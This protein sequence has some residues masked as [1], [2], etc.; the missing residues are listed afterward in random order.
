MRLILLFA[1]AAVLSACVPVGQVAEIMADGGERVLREPMREPTPGPRVLV[2]GLDG[3]GD[4]ILRE[5]LAAGAMPRLAELVEP[6][7]GDVWAHAYA[8][9]R[10]PSVFPSE[11]AAGWAALF[12]GQPPAVN[13]VTGNEWFDR[14]S[15]AVYAP[16]PLSVG[17]IR[18]TLQI[19][20]DDLLGRL[21]VAPTLFER[22]DV[23]SHVSMGFVHRGADVLNPPDLGDL[24]DL[25]GVA[26]RIVTG[27]D[28]VAAGFRALDNDTWTGVRRSARRYGLPRLQVAYFPGVDLAMHAG[29]RGD[30]DGEFAH[31]TDVVDRRI[32]DILDLYASEG[33]LRD[34]Y[35]LV[36]SDHGH[37]P[38]LDDDRHSLYSGSPGEPPDLFASI[39]VRLRPFEIGA[40]TTDDDQAVMTYNEAVAM[41][42][43]TDRS[44]CPNAG[45]TCD[46]T[47]GPRLVEDVLPVA[48]AF[49]EAHAT[50]AHAASL[51][52]TLDLLFVRATG[53]AE[54]PSPPYRVF[55][56]T[57]DGGRLVD[58][59]AYIE[60]SGRTDLFRLP[61]RLRWLT[62]GPMG[63]RAGDVL[64]LAKAGL[65]RPVEE[66]FYFGAPRLSGHGSAALSDG[67][68]S[69]V[70]AHPRRTGET[71]RIAMLNAVGESPTQLDVTPMILSL[72][73]ADR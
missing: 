57:P 22:A 64:V 28:P 14:D 66:R 6:A 58:V 71:L 47:R 45:D 61:E 41:I 42:F 19:Y 3:I 7:E 4:A 25:L 17:T 56:P 46:W 1:A 54:G 68:I 55:E 13:G 69:F 70:L 48:R 39:G 29:A 30:G 40:D 26:L 49:A 12:T 27:G 73:E 15:A 34:T 32:G 20:T 51:R 53:G 11:T 36:V 50:G 24:P 43:L 62:E 65:E 21:I 31:L 2:L 10:V 72:L 37:T 5:A 44:A 23:R 18:Q 9:P 33:A 8:A 52:G 67:A 60:A 38:L 63:R 16:V 59:E 35:V